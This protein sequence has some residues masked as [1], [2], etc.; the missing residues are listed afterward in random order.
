MRIAGKD[1]QDAFERGRRYSDQAGFLKRTGRWR[2]RE[3]TRK[4]A[5]ETTGAVGDRP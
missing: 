5:P 2:R 3:R 1:A 4:Q